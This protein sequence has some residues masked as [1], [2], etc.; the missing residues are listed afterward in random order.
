MISNPEAKEYYNDQIQEINEQK[1]KIEK[2]VKDKYHLL[3]KDKHAEFTF[4]S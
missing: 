1:A 3:A 2:D 4:K